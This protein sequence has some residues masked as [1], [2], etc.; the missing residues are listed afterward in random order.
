M[1]AGCTDRIIDTGF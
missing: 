1:Q